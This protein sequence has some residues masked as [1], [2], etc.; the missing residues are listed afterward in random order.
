MGVGCAGVWRGGRGADGRK[1]LGGLWHGWWGVGQGEWPVTNCLDFGL[2]EW[3]F[4]V[5]MCA[6]RHV[7][8]R[9]LEVTDPASG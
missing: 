2:I 7:S 1:E 8:K 6:T 3:I 4:D 5:W 9:T